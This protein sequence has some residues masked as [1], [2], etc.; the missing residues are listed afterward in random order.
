MI[1][2]FFPH[3]LVC[4]SVFITLCWCAEELWKT[5]KQRILLVLD[6]FLREASSEILLCDTKWGSPFIL[7]AKD[8]W[9]TPAQ[10]GT[11]ECLSMLAFSKAQVT[12]AAAKTKPGCSKCPVV[13]RFLQGK[14]VSAGVLPSRQALLIIS[15]LAGQKLAAGCCSWTSCY[16]VGAT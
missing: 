2:W 15:I 1:L 16:S 8:I 12:A 13:V 3:H 11:A 9:Q 4:C 5:R 10:V 14:P 6:S 7:D